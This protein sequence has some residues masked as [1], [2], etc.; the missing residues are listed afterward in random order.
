MTAPSRAPQGV[1][2][3]AIDRIVSRVMTSGMV[4]SF[5]CYA[6]GLVLLFLRKEAVLHT[7]QQ[8]YHSL[9][10]FFQ[11]IASGEATPFL[12]LGTASLILT[13]FVLVLSS[14]LAF[15]R[16]RDRRFAVIATLVLLVMIASVIVGSVFKLKI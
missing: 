16:Q 8:Y 13:P 10:Q 7:A 15:M 14:V 9:P 11:A 12:Y 6:I 2:T 3:E 5:A 1:A 4:V